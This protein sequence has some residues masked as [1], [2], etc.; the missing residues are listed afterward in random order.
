[1]SDYFP[2]SPRK[3]FFYT[4]IFSLIL[5]SWPVRHTL[6]ILPLTVP[7]NLHHIDVPF[8]F[9]D[10]S[11]S[12]RLRST[13]GDL[14]SVANLHYYTSITRECPKIRP[15]LTYIH[16]FLSNMDKMFIR[17]PTHPTESYLYLRSI[18]RYRH[19]DYVPLLLDLNP[20][21]TPSSWDACL[22]RLLMSSGSLTNLR[23]YPPYTPV[24]K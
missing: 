13:S 7:I 18:F 14:S 4:H 17:P 9:S 2:S 22:V 3:V 6:S 15:P 8:L 5:P 19:L 10:V 16:V 24:T 21:P 1:M 11:F 20:S 12:P 23:S